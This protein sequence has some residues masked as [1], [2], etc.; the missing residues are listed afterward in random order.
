MKLAEYYLDYIENG[1]SPIHL[2]R[3]KKIG[4][5]DK[6]IM[7]CGNVNALNAAGYILRIAENYKNETMNKEYRI[8]K[9]AK[10]RISA[11]HSN[12]KYHD[13][14]FTPLRKPA[15]SD[16]EFNYWLLNNFVIDNYG[17]SIETLVESPCKT[18]IELKICG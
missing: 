4:L 6:N 1:D 12:K 7:S 5:A 15:I 16:D 2:V 3:K 10:Q 13:A 17:K 8:V 18:D 11:I 9:T 14:V